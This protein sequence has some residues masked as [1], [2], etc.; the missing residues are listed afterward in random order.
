ML[1]NEATQL[2]SCIG[3]DERENRVLELAHVEIC[4]VMITPSLLGVRYIFLLVDMFPQKIWVFFLKESLGTSYIV[5]KFKTTIEER[6][7]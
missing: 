4:G 2:G 1:H 7:W 6:M 5:Q 3:R